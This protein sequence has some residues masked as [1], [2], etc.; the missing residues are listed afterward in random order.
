M[1]GQSDELETFKTRVNLT[2]FAASEGFVLDI[3]ASSRNSAVMRH[4]AGDKIIVARGED[5]HWVFFSTR[6]PGDN[7]TIIDFVQR[8]KGGTLGQ[9]RQVLRPWIGSTPAPERARLDPNQYV[10]DLAPVTRDLV[11]VRARFE[12][13]GS[14]EPGNV[15]LTRERCIPSWLLTHPAV[16]DTIRV[17]ERGNVC[18]AHQNEDGLCGYEIK[19]VGFTG[20][21]SGG[22][23]GLWSVTLEEPVRVLVVAETALD[24]LSYLAIRGGRDTR[25]VSIA[26][27]PNPEQP[28]LLRTAMQELPAGGRVIAAMDRDAGGDSLTECLRGIFTELGR[29]DLALIDDRP[30]VQGTDWNDELRRA[31]PSQL[32]DP[33][34]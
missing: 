34:P 33:T 25:I 32:P 26:G 20:F 30:E 7:G 14:V 1:T 11:A 6:D 12:A 3:K 24:G 10:R 21:A 28:R 15:Y 19:N 31:D 29:G 18:L 4:P 17:D 23:K 22:V 2:E 5:G 13:M 8:R 16:A 9:V 27:Q